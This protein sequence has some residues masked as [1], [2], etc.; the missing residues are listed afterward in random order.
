MLVLQCTVNGISYDKVEAEG[1][2]LESLEAFFSGI[3]RLTSDLV[4]CFPN[5]QCL[6][7]VGQQDLIAIENINGLG[8]LKELWVAECSIKVNI[9]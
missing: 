4:T 2:L 3:P 1:P 9:L 7:I 5:L 8:K 6:C